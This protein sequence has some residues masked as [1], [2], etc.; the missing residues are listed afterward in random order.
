M[1]RSRIR[2]KKRQID[3][4]HA[5]ANIFGELAWTIVAWRT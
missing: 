4:D 1:Q 2:L 5:Q 3:L